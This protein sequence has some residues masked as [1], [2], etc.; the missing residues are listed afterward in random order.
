MLETWE[1]KQ[2]AY[3][4]DVDYYMAELISEDST[5]RP[6][7]WEQDFA[8]CTIHIKMPSIKGIMC[9]IEKYNESLSSA[10]KCDDIWHQVDFN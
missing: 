2:T 8:G 7:C 4:L 3:I 9:E 5:Y 1:I 6:A 10:Q